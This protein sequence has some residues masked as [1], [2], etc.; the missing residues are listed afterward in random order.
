MT[1]KAS[2]KSAPGDE[3]ASP[4]AGA[5]PKVAREHSFADE[6][7][8]VEN[9]FTCSFRRDGGGDCGEVY[10]NR[11]GTMKYRCAWPMG[12]SDPMH[13]AAYLGHYPNP[14]DPEWMAYDHRFEWLCEGYGFPAR[15]FYREA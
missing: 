10:T 8:E 3:R 7:C 12:H 14:G 2:T 4:S 13:H 6:Y 9:A 15:E 5:K 11:Y 1:Q